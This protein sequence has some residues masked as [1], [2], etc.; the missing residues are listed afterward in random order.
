MPTVRLR[1]N[2]EEKAAQVPTTT[3]LLEFLRDHVGVTGPKRGCEMAECGACMVHVD[4]VLKHACLTLAALVDG[5][6]VLT[7]EGLGRPGNLHPLQRAFV[8]RLGSQ[9]GFCTPGQ[10]MSALALFQ[11]N[12]DP[13]EEEI[14]RHMVGNLCRCTGYYKIVE[15]IQVAAAEMEQGRAGVLADGDAGLS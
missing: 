4:G 15:S 9:C 11:E 7:V 1:V 12:P 6:E 2:G 13:G 3:S 10:I 14:K 5:S 8:E